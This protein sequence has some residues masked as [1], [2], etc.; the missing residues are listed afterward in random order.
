MTQLYLLPV[1][2]LVSLTFDLG[3]I[4]RKLLVPLA[5]LLCSVFLQSKRA[6]AM[7]AAPEAS[8]EQPTVDEDF[9]PFSGDGMYM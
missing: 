5:V 7:A 9:D 8:A 2:F 3:R 1:K 6:S 4:M